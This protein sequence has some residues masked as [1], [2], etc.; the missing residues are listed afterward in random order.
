MRPE[1]S[2]TTEDVYEALGPFRVGD[3]D[4]WI[5]LYLVASIGELLDE[6]EQVIRDSDTHSGWG[7]YMDLAV[8]P[9]EALPW[10]AQFK[11]VT[12]ANGLS[13]EVQRD[14]IAGAQGF[15]RGTIGAIRE[16]ARAYLKSTKIVDITERDTSPYHFKVRVW[17][18]QLA[19]MSYAELA[20]SY[21]TYQDVIDEFPIY[22]DF[23]TDPTRLDRAL[24]AAKP[25][26]LV[27]V[28]EK[29][30]GTPPA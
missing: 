7:T 9:A 25:A 17:L 13:I 20:A 29:T 15:G 1:V 19:G 21:P 14:L 3:D 23:S 28:V 22:A 11:G 12:I 8:A 24:A 26:G 10:L 5:L 2:E 18:E 16:T 30:A 4:D 6:T 27:M